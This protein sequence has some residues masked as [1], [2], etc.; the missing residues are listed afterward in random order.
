MNILIIIIIAVVAIYI[1][2]KVTAIKTDPGVIINGVEWATCNLA[3]SG[4]FTGKPE[5]KG[6]LLGQYDHCP[7]G[8]HLPKRTD[9]D[10][11]LDKDK[12]SIEKANLNGTIGMRFV[13]KDTGNS[14]FLPAAGC[15]AGDQYRKGGY[16]WCDDAVDLGEDRLVGRWSYKFMVFDAEANPNSINVSYYTKF[17]QFNKLSIRAVRAK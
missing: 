8:W 7:P 15:K 16:Y 14:M 6:K 3:G 9:F 2:N 5:H 4:S 11:L 10:A 12:V 17:V 13:D 1:F